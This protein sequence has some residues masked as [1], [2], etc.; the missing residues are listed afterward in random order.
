MSGGEYLARR[1]SL[2]SVKHWSVL[3]EAEDEATGV[4]II[5]GLDDETL[6]AHV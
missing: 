2:E 3:K 6:L 1:S 4:K 5:V